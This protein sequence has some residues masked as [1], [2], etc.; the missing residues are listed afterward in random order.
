MRKQI[1]ENVG[2]L[3]NLQKNET[4][5]QDHRLMWILTTQALIFTGLC[6]LFNIEESSILRETLFISLWI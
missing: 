1:N 5:H 3:Y 4:E 6:S 2:Y